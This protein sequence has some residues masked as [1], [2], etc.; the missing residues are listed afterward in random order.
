MVSENFTI[1]KMT[2]YDL[3]LA[4]PPEPEYDSVMLSSA[5]ADAQWQWDEMLDRI[6]SE[7]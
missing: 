1:V 2:Q 3:D 5:K 7:E 6:E 4:S